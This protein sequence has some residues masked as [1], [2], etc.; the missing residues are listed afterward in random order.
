VSFADLVIWEEMYSIRE[1][2][3][4]RGKCKNRKKRKG[5]I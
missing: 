3:K 5:K 4:K 2:R 1:E